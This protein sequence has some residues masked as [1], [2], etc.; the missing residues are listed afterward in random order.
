MPS[1]VAKV[2]L[3]RLLQI[4]IFVCLFSSCLLKFAIGLENAL[5]SPS[6]RWCG[7]APA[8][9]LPWEPA[10]QTAALAN[11]FPS[12]KVKSIATGKALQECLQDVN[13]CGEQA[14]RQSR[15]T[16]GISAL[17]K[18]TPLVI[19]G[20]GNARSCALVGNSGNLLKQPYGQYIDKHDIV[21]R[22]NLLKINEKLSN[23][24][25]NKTTIRMLNRARSISVCKNPR[26]A[27]PSSEAE[28]ANSTAKS[29]G[30]RAVALWNPDRV[31]EYAQCIRDKFV[32]NLE[33]FPISKELRSQMRAVYRRVHADA[34]HLGVQGMRPLLAPQLTSGAH[35]GMLLSRMCNTISL[36]GISTYTPATALE[37]GAYKYTGMK[38]PKHGI[39]WH[40]WVLESAGWRLMH[41]AGIATIC[42]I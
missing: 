37:G 14:Y 21:I 13:R 41:A 36:Y 34:L 24:V 17:L 23:H 38:L 7:G 40:D 35:A 19:G 27:L 26:K 16:K 1:L 12:K 25:G 30:L 11:Q 20:M 4:R 10:S 2:W 3:S 6:P 29:R 39:T 18:Q 42:A 32:G 8:S 5:V 15:T 9:L 28:Q 22:M 31:E 33:V